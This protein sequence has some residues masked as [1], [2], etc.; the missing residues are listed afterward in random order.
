MRRREIENISTNMQMNVRCARGK[1][2]SFEADAI[3]ANHTPRLLAFLD[4]WRKQPKYPIEVYLGLGDF[5][6]FRL[7]DAQDYRKYTRFCASITVGHVGSP[8]WIRDFESTSHTVA[9]RTLG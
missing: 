1:V 7:E 9:Q 6:Y 4:S 3:L 5:Q 8:V 2:N